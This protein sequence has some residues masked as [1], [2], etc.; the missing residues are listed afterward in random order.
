[1]IR[2]VSSFVA[3]MAQ[4]MACLV[5]TWYVGC[6]S[7]MFIFDPIISNTRHGKF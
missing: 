5:E 7:N 1:M 4:Y 6:D 2:I 3:I